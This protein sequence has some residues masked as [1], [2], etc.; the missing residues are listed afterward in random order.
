MIK[1][2]N[3]LSWEE[4]IMLLQAISMG[5]VDKDQLYEKRFLPSSTRIFFWDS[6]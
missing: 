3:D 5:E 4:K 1:K 2:L 6:W